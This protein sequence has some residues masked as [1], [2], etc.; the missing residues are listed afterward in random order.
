MLSVFVRSLAFNLLFY[1][2]VAL[3]SL[4]AAVMALVWPGA[5]GRCARIWA[6]LWLSGYERICGVTYEVRGREHLPKGGYLVAAKHQSMWD[7]FAL[8]AILPSPVYAFK[9][10]I[11]L[12]PVFGQVL[13]ALGC[14]PVQ[15][16]AG[17]RALKRMTASAREACA[18]GRQVVIFPEGTRVEVGQASTYHTG[19]SHLYQ[20]LGVPCVPV[21]LNSGVL[22][23]KDAFMR[24][25]GVITVEILPAI[26]PGMDR[27]KMH[28]LLEAQIQSAS[29][30]L[31]TEASLP[32][33]LRC[34]LQDAPIPLERMRG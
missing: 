25:P 24:P 22:W 23:P 30:R 20:A 17:R 34:P 1:A 4:L 21:A 8:F 18:R 5:L 11:L 26:A 33:H 2:Y 14:I 12:I 16:G 15:R 32:E 13:Q 27:R 6:R 9:S 28:A 3:T 31:C 7:N 29:L 19:A 10:K